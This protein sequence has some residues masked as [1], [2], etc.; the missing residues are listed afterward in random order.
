MSN[1]R[2]ICTAKQGVADSQ[3]VM[4]RQV[5]VRMQVQ[6]HGS[7]AA[8]RTEAAHLFRLDRASIWK[9]LSAERHRAASDGVGGPS[10]ARARRRHTFGPSP[11][12]GYMCGP[13]HC[14]GPHVTR[15]RARAAEGP[16]A[17]SPLERRVCFASPPYV[18]R[19]RTASGFWDEYEYSS[20]TNSISEYFRLR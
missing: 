9:M 20:E 17:C 5:T 14:R 4:L 10:R 19:A 8:Q 16:P 1:L 13:C 15:G 18:R 12:H 7:V 6:R 2:P 3:Q 11:W